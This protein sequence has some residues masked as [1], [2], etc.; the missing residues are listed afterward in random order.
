M[1]EEEYIPPVRANYVG[2]PEMLK[3]EIFG[4]IVWDYFGQPPYQVGSSLKT[5]NFR[6][7]DVRLIL[8]DDEFEKFVGVRERPLRVGP[9]WSSLCM[10]FSALG[11]ELTGLPIDFQIQR[12]TEA[13]EEYGTCEHRR[14][15]IGILPNRRYPVTA[16]MMD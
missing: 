9:M 7:V 1:S 2:M 11:R 12:M 4:S 16:E 15:A 3:L 14:N 5:R 10:A 6:D 13:N 8:D